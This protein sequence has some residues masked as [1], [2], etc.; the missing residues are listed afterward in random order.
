[1]IPCEVFVVMSTIENIPILNTQGEI[2]STT[3]ENMMEQLFVVHRSGSIVLFSHHFNEN[4]RTS[5]PDDDL[6]GTAIDAMDRLLGEILSNEGHIRQIVHENKVLSFSYGRH[7]SFI[8]VSSVHATGAL[9]RL[10]GFS[11]DFELQF[12]K[13]LGMHFNVD[14]Q[15]YQAA[16]VLVHAHFA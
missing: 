16:R 3:L 7:C 9:S 1:M 4:G 11:A 15:E 6:H 12:A 2:P 5:L 8:L 10:A 14:M 13:K